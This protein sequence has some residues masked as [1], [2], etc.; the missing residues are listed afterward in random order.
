[1]HNKWRVYIELN[2]VWDKE[3]HEDQVKA[4]EFS[5]PFWSQ[6]WLS[7]SAV[8]MDAIGGGSIIFLCDTEEEAYSIYEQV[9]GNDG[10]PP[11]YEP[12]DC[13]AMLITNEG[14]G[15]RENT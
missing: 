14:K 7:T 4:V 10:L 11:D 5:L 9:R 6:Y 1:M 2:P 3:T 12:G 8:V 15:L 13:Y